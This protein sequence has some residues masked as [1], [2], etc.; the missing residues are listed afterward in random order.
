MEMQQIMEML[1]EMRADQKTMLE[2]IDTNQEKTD[3]KW[4]ADREERKQE[5]RAG[6]ELM[7]SLVSRMGAH[8]E[9]IMACLGKMDDMDLK[10]NP[11]EKES[12]AVHK[13]VSKEHTAVKPIGGLRKWHRGQN[14]ATECCQKP[15]EWSRISCGS[16][17]KFAA[18]K[19]HRAKETS[20]GK[21][22][23]GTVLNKKPGKDRHSGRDNSHARKAVRE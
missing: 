15:K 10:A 11:E 12:K 16:Q 4:E 5:I 7:A 1:A 18:V 19:W 13:E 9:R 21:T 23:P 17:R 20:S 14:L 3:A 22:G 2:K 6:L 8:Q